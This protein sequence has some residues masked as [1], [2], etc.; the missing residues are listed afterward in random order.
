MKKLSFI[1][2]FIIG[3]HTPDKAYSQ[4]T[5]LP[6]PINSPLG[7]ELHPSVSADGKT[8]LFLSNYGEEKPYP[9]ISY[10]KSGVWTR[11]A[12]I[13]P[14][15]ANSTKLNN[16]LGYNLSPMGD[17]IFF[18]S[19]RYGGV[20]NNDIWIVEKTSTGWS[21]PKNPGKPLNSTLGESD[22]SLSP[23]GKFLYFVR[24][25]D[26]KSS[27]G[28]PCGKIMVSQR[29]SKEG[30][31]E[32]T[33]LPAPVNSGCE[34]S[35]RILS[36][37]KTLIFSSERAG[38]KGGFDFYKSQKKDDGNWTTPVP[39]T[40]INTKEDEVYAAI[41]ANAEMIYYTSSSAKSKDIFRSKLSPEFQPDRVLL[42]AGKI[43]DETGKS[44]PGKIII[45]EL[46]SLKLTS[47]YNL[48]QDEPFLLILPKGKT[49]DVTAYGSTK[50]WFYDGSAIPLDTLTKSVYLE[51]DFR[52]P[53]GKINSIIDLSDIRFEGTTLAPSSTMELDKLAKWLQ[54][55]PTAS[56]EITTYIPEVKKDTI[57]SSDLT[58]VT[59]EEVME[60]NTPSSRTIYHNDITPKQADAI[61]AYLIKK[62]VTSNR[63]KAVGGG[64]KKD[65]SDGTNKVEI[66]ILKE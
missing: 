52:L 63:I 49:F 59:Q 57:P 53:I 38:G 60:D 9:V 36:D 22:P 58:E 42:L 29:T 39:L 51:Q 34:C 37:G 30:F 66:I 54:E 26:K 28:L 64:D 16:N 5:S 6:Q 19:N 43:K 3:F 15:N 44:I 62:G 12:E 21:S 2:F 18:S 35:P 33:E 27:T 41:P 10:L 13:A 55:N 17:E 1:L 32:P 40:Y 20:G 23:D 11:P 14:L 7:D 24:W 45:T 47:V 61:S 8:L 46:P 48:K 4:G 25:T 50:G 65:V 56:I 31:R